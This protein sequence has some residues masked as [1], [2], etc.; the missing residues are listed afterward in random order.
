M[1]VSKLSH[2]QRLGLALVLCS[3]IGCVSAE[4]RNDHSS[5]A[6]YASEE[7][8]PDWVG[9]PQGWSRLESIERWLRLGRC[10]QNNY[11]TVQAELTLGEGRLEF[12][13]ED[14]GSASGS[15]AWLA[16]LGSAQAGFR[17]VLANPAA[18]STQ[19]YRAQQGLEEILTMQQA[20]H[21]ARSPGAIASSSGRIS[22][23]TWRATAPD[24]NNVTRTNGNYDRITLHHTA[25]VP[26]TR[27]DGSLS[28]SIDV[29]QKVQRN[30]MQ[31]QGY[32]DIGYHFLIDAQGRIFEGRALQY[33]GAHAGKRN[34]VNNNVKNIG[35]CM[36]GN[37]EYGQPSASAMRSL[38]DLLV[39][40]R[41]KYGI[42]RSS[43]KSHGELKATECPGPM[44]ARWTSSY[45]SS[46]PRLASDQSPRPATPSYAK[47][48][49]RRSSSSSAVR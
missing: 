4:M 44:L 23:S 22:R 21:V 6:I 38:E 39:Q 28:D 32:G 17:R 18:N 5:G 46:G 47:A 10:S 13:R 43:I 42:D 41:S 29:L 11:W 45:R 7:A 33:Q 3:T 36:I 12:A 1:E 31:Q 34:S 40:L 9:A 16:R 37:Y 15:S 26:G 35:V 25:Q 14:A 2:G 24:L 27:F 30:H 8:T 20:V 49:P 48:A 19:I